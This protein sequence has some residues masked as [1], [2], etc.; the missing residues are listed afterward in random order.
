VRDMNW[1]G[2]VQFTLSEVR[3]GFDELHLTFHIIMKSRKR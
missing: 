1:I 2:V 3:W